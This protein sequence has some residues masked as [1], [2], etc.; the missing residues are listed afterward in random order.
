MHAYVASTL[1]TELPPALELMLMS[2]LVPGQ[3]VEI[4]R[5]PLEPFVLPFGAWLRTR[6]AVK[7]ILG[8]YGIVHFLSCSLEP[9]KHISSG[10]RDFQLSVCKM[11]IVELN[12]FFHI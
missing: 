9:Q 3:E 2:F 4:C 8:V 11:C 5:L 1:P 12:F 7:T 10:D 6:V